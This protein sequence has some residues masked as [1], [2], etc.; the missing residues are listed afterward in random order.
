MA[1]IRKLKTYQVIVLLTVIS[2]TLIQQVSFNTF[3]SVCKHYSLIYTYVYVGQFKIQ[4]NRF[5][6]SSQFCSYMYR[7]KCSR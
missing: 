2:I 5:K 3:T 4:D 7:Y 1:I 6:Q